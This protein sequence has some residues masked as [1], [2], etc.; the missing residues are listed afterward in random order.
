LKQFY[1]GNERVM[2][3]ENKVDAQDKHINGSIVI[4]TS[5]MKPNIAHK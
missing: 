3:V 1:E 2:K 4:G 5:W